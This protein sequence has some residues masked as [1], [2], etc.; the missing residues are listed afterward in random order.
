M[1]KNN[2]YSEYGGIVHDSPTKKEIQNIVNILLNQKE[3]IFDEVIKCLNEMKN[4]KLK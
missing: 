2:N 3:H 4:L 1:E